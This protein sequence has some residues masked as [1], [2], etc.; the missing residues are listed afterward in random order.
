MGIRATYEHPKPCIEAEICVKN[1][2]K[3]AGYTLLVRFS[4]FNF[5]FVY[6]QNFG[7]LVLVRFRLNLHL[8]SALKDLSQH[9]TGI[10]S[11][12]GLY[13]ELWILPLAQLFLCY[14]QTGLLETVDQTRLSKAAL[15]IWLLEATLRNDLSKAAL[16]GD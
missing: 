15:Q 16:W 2:T 12:G 3:S 5:L 7:F 9:L 10:F 8:I 4:L 11:T 1:L 13:T 14:L 6:H